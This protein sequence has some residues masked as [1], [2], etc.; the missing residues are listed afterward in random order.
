M[1][2]RRLCNRLE[3]LINK[4]EIRS[5]FVVLFV[6]MVGVT[7][8]DHGMAANFSP[9]LTSSA[10]GAP[11]IGQTTIL[12]RKF[13]TNTV[14]IPGG[15]YSLPIIFAKDHT[16]YILDG[17]ITATGTA[18][19]V[20]ASKVI[21]NLNG[22]TI[23]YNQT[24]PGD[25]VY[26]DVYNKTDIAI[27]NGAIIQGAAM[28]EG[29]QYGD[30]NN[31]VRSKGTT[32]LQIALIKV[33]YGGRD[34]GGFHVSA[35][36]SIFEQNI[37]EDTWTV[38]TFKN[39]HQGIDAISAGKGDTSNVYRNNVIK[40][41]RHR[42][43]RT[44]NYD[45]VYG[46]I[47]TINSLAANS[48][49][50]MGY[51][52]RHVQVYNNSIVGKGE[53]PIGIGFVSAGTH[54]ILI[55]NNVIDV[56]TTSIGE[57]YGGSSACFN[58]ATPCGNYAIGFRTTWG[59]NNI[60]FHD[61]TITVHSDSRY[62]GTYAPTGKSVLVSGKGRGLMV[63][64][65]AGEKAKF[66]NNT[67]TSLDKDGTGKAY[68]IACTGGNSG[69]MIFESNTITSNILNVALSDE[70]GACAGYPLFIRNTFIKTGN[71]PSYKTVAAELGGYSE[72]T[73]RFVSN[74]YRGGA[75]PQSININASGK[76]RKSI[77]FGRE[78]AL[79]LLTLPALSPITTAIFTIQKGRTAVNSAGTIG[80]N[81]TAKAVIYNHELHNDNGTS[82]VTLTRHLAPHTLSFSMS[83]AVFVTK[84]DSSSRAWDASSTSGSY[85]LPL[86][87][88]SGKVDYS[89]QLIITIDY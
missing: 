12:S 49:G 53:H 38:G 20:R 52:A 6:I 16:E 69:E 87:D 62:R 23:T 75:S 84:A 35:V 66:Y 50:I 57:E 72:G 48:Y 21:V 44:G 33:R 25:G 4:T 89:K 82:H 19:L 43:I 79:S 61:N 71:Y 86:Y 58:P 56:Q 45:E 47:I 32:R 28:S 18:I 85:V 64:I 83:A 76:S 26:V 51:Q 77:Y 13:V 59:A 80:P 34:V 42:G 54:D 88:G 60:D 39:R 11:P 29:D 15:H 27:T 9:L 40:N 30:G 24:I 55:Y 7:L 67:I 73:G 41:C 36:N 70:Y 65:N 3:S 1:R 31:P 5:L 14:H 22:N 63:A 8:I 68:A 17:D 46:N 10:D 2:M 37:L 81:G 78:I 74:A